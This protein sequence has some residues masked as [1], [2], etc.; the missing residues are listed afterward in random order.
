MAS[1]RSAAVNAR[2]IYRNGTAALDDQPTLA[3]ITEGGVVD[4]NTVLTMTG[5]FDS[6][7]L[8]YFKTA[9]FSPTQRAISHRTMHLVK[10][11][12]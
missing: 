5:G 4:I 1:G 12:V 3:L 6:L 9:D 8:E 11:G 10:T 7:D 2:V